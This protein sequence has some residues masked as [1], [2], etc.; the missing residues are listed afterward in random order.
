M[1]LGNIL[2]R[3]LDIKKDDIQSPFCC[4][5]VFLSVQ[6]CR[7]GLEAAEKNLKIPAL[8]AAEALNSPRLDELS[9]MTYLSYFLNVNSPGYDAT[10]AW[11]NST[12]KGSKPVKDF[13]VSKK[14]Q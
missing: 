10:L 7:F 8:L 13:T 6:R 4:S 3:W 2:P 5:C 11:V 1:L 12:L 14:M 9:G